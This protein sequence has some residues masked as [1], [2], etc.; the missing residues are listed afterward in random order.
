[1]IGVYKIKK[2][3][4][5]L[6]LIATM[7]SL[8]SCKTDDNLYEDAVF[9]LENLVTVNGVDPAMVNARIESQ[10]MIHS[11][12]HHSI[13]TASDRQKMVEDWKKYYELD[14]SKGIKVVGIETEMH[15]GN[16][17]RT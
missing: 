12:C 7:L 10:K 2:L 5:L 14:Y 1:M 16:Y 6:V 15:I 17:I 4:I 8:V 13:K 11:S 9:V 3:L